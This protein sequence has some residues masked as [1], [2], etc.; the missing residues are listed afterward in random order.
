MIIHIS[1]T[2]GSGKTYLGKKIKKKYP[3]FVVYDTDLF[4]HGV[5]K[6]EV[7]TKTKWKNTLERRINSFIRK[8]KRKFI[9]FVGD[10]NNYSPDGSRYIIKQSKL[11]IFYDVKLPTLLKRYY[12]REVCDG[13]LKDKVY[14][15][16]IINGEF[17]IPSTK[18]FISEYKKDIKW[19]EKYKY[20]FLN[21]KQILNLI[22][23]INNL[24][25]LNE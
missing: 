23:N 2:P 7:R 1:G 9:I 10:L 4:L 20:D 6:S 22:D 12:N 19:H 11:N 17:S 25:D 14:M 13:L 8:N 18:K 21:E 24:L 3:K 16:D 5:K 15:D